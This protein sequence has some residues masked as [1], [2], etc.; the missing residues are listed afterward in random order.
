[1]VSCD[2]VTAWEDGGIGAVVIAIA[3]ALWTWWRHKTQ[4]AEPR[5]QGGPS[6]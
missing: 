1:M 5:G 3:W 4:S 6:R 2:L